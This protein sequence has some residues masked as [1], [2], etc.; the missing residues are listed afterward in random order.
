MKLSASRPT[1]FLTPEVDQRIKHWAALATGEMSCLGST[2]EV[3]GG[4]LVS[5]VHL[6]HQ[7]CGHAET[8]M[9]HASVARL[10]AELDAAG[11]DV[12]RLRFWQH[13]HGTLSTF[14][15]SQDEAT[16]RSL[17]NGEWTVALVCN[18]AGDRQA[19][20]DIWWPVHVTLDDLPIE[21][22]HADLGLRTE[23]E[24]EFKE[25][26]TETAALPSVTGLTAR[27]LAED[28]GDSIS[29]RTHFAE[30]DWEELDDLLDP[31]GPDGRGFD[32]GP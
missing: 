23:C 28:R 2:D 32:A 7:K 19:R 17:A 6:L 29:P 12:S 31:L 14:F 16:I 5:K 4:F 15:S 18:K 8:E 13:S 27:L 24:R 9:D 26:V 20:V 3:P 22:F 21:V 30:L 11:E 1:L 10:V 25:R